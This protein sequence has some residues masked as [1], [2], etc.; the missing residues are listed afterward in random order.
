MSDTHSSDRPSA[1][2]H[3]EAHGSAL[4]AHLVAQQTNM[5]LMFL[6]QVP[7]P[8]TNERICDL[9]AAQLF[10]TTLEML[11]AKTR[12]NLNTQEASLLRQNL[13]SVRMAFVEAVNQGPASSAASA[14][15][16]QPS[17]PAEAPGSSQAGHD[18]ESKPR[19]SKKY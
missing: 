10:I 7:N 13:T 4:F 11:E 17:S 14:A 5:A 6:G 16:A 2:P 19:F 9:D 15:S 1:D 3:A 8:E 12:G 18:D